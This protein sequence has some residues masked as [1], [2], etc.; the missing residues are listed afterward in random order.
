MLKKF[1]WSINRD[2]KSAVLIFLIY[3]SLNSILL[4]ASLLLTIY[5][6]KISNQYILLSLGAVYL[7]F[8]YLILKRADKH[9]FIN[10]E[11]K[12]DL[13]SKIFIYIIIFS[14]TIL[15]YVLIAFLTTRKY[16][17]KLDGVRIVIYLFLTPT[18][19]SA[20]FIYM[21][22]IDVGG[23]FKDFLAIFQESMA[24]DREKFQNPNYMWS[25][26]DISELRAYIEF[27]KELSRE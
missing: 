8:N 7:T 27:I 4:P 12:V 16:R 24:I 6:L 3:F 26:D 19:L 2:I 15:S 14:N 1:N 22:E 9:F 25:G 10:G 11:L 17:E 18:L 21:Y 23:Y 5:Y 13:I 20:Y